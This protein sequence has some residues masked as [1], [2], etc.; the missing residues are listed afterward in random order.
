LTKWGHTKKKDGGMG[1]YSKPTAVAA[2]ASENH[3]LEEPDAA[4]HEPNHA[5]IPSGP[6]KETRD[7][8]QLCSRK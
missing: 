7:N 2:Q 6:A 8:E 1:V 3:L 5:H 4:D